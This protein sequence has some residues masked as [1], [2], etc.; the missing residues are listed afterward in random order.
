[1]VYL[2]KLEWAG[3]MPHRKREVNLGEEFD[4]G[5]RAGLKARSLDDA[6]MTATFARTTTCLSR[7]HG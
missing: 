6:A 2:P 5:A 4:N 1:M 3:E 7:S